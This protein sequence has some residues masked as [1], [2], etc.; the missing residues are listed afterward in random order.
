MITTANMEKYRNGDF[1]QFVNNVLELLPQTTADQLNI[2]GQRTVLQTAAQSF[3]NA[4]LPYTGSDITPE[5]QALDA[6]RDNA[7]IGIKMILEAWQ[8]HFDPETKNN[9]FALLDILNRF[10]ERIYKLR[11]QLETA[12]INSIVA[13]WEEKHSDKISQLQLTDWVNELKI[14]NQNFN[15]KYIARTVQLSEVETGVLATARTA[16]TEACRTLKQHIEAHALLTP[17]AEYD[18]LMAK[19]SSLVNQYNLAV[20]KYSSTEESGGENQK[21]ESPETPS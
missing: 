14:S 11:Y 6:Q 18:Q 20:T 15:N 2:G 3:N 21:P 7:V 10:G 1:L 12:T 13:E 5:I 8:Y 4:Y 16:S 17:N 19:L 9:A